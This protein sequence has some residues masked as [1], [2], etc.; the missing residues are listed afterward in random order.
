MT[1]TQIARRDSLALNDPSEDWLKK[2]AMDIGKEV[3][4]YI[5]VMYPEAI[6]A[7]AST[8][9]LSVRNTIYNQIVSAVREAKVEA[10]PEQWFK[11]REDFRR[12]WIA[13]YRQLRKQT[14]SQEKPR[15]T[16]P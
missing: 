1:Q 16:L 8:F 12:R 15:L 13:Q 5:E 3:V 9:R 4:A 14:Q 6:T 7:T 10:S 2:L 11:R